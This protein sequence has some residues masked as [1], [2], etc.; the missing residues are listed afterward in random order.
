MKNFLA[1]RRVDHIIIP[2]GMT[3]YLQTHDNAINKP[4]KDHVRMEVNGYIEIE[5][6]E[7]SVET[8]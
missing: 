8:L 4:F 6:K 5:W 3:S 1:E 2:A 7:I